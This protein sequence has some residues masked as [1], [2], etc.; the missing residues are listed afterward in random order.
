MSKK[1][2]KIPSKF[3]CP[4][5]HSIYIDPVV[6][7]SGNSYERQT[8]VR[9]LETSCTDPLTREQV[10]SQVYSNRHL[11]SDIKD[12]IESVS[13]IECDDNDC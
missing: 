7:S 12:Y 6:L 13:S 4:I 11:Q 3:F 2:L 9:W 5:T 10:E 8:I 1:S